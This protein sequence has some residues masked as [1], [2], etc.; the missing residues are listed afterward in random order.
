M[1]LNINES[2]G[3]YQGLFGYVDEGGVVENVTVTGA[4]TGKSH[5]GGV[6]G[7]N[8]GT[9]QNCVNKAAITGNDNHVGGVVGYNRNIMSGC[10]NTGEV[11][12]LHKVGGVVGQV[13]S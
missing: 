7:Q 13:D 12:G 3:D 5:V 2:D 11:K 4:V 9:V 8:I 10:H 6:A 1:A